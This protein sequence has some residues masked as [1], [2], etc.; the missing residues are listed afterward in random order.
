VRR[1]L[2]AAAVLAAG[3]ALA[4]GSRADDQKTPLP[5]ADDFTKAV[6]EISKT[7]PTDG[8]HK[9][10]WPKKGSWPG[11]TRD[12][13]YD[14][15]K[16]CEGDAEKRCFCCGLTF[17]VFFRAYEKC[18]QDAKKPFKILDLD[19]KGVTELRKEWFGPTAEDRHTLEKAITK[20]N[21]GKK[22]D[23]AQ[24]RAGDFCQLWRHS[25]S[26][27]SVLLLEVE[28]D[29]KG[30]PTA[31]RYWSTQNSTNGVHENTE[32]FSDEKSGV[33]EAETYV[34]RVGKD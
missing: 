1:S 16:V 28:K 31:L 22:V 14:G 30:K 11:T 21:L 9:Y 23:L 6:L 29:S 20:Y 13:F 19:A 18:C 12:L 10:Y 17:E 3:L 24:A 26:G 8:T 34:A 15:E 33:I 5:A 32:K 4:G 7:Y 2:I 25:G 27:H